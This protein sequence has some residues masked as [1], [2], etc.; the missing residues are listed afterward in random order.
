MD[1]INNILNGVESGDYDYLPRFKKI[2]ETP[3][4][5]DLKTVNYYLK[6][7]CMPPIS[8]KEL[9]S[10]L[11][12]ITFHREPANDYDFFN[13]DAE[14]KTIPVWHLDDVIHYYIRN[15]NMTFADLKRIRKKTNST[16]SYGNTMGNGNTTVSLVISIPVI[17][18][19][20]RI[21]TDSIILEST[22]MISDK[23]FLTLS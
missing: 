15:A 19:G 14:F 22:D 4:E 21:W 12:A 20:D 23:E 11:K 10:D 5:N 1:L 3:T 8:M 18:K 13:I 7:I 9:K 17:K 16:W 6:A 2:E